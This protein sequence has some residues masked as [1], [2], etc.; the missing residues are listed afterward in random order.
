[1]ARLHA[2]SPLANAARMD[3]P[4]LLVAGGEDQRVGIAGVIEYAARL[5]LAGKDI[6]LLVDDEAGH[7]GGDAVSREA[8][9]FVMETLLHAHL[10]GMAPP[11]A[12]AGLRDYLMRNLRLKGSDFAKLQ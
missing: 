3:R 4:L 11:A 1:M 9:L 6:S 8:S 2:Q 10:G 5:K 7:S 12:D